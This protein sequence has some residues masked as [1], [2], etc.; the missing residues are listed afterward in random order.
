MAATD[1]DVADLQKMERVLA[2]M[3]QRLGPGHVDCS[4]A[5]ANLARLLARASDAAAL[6][7]FQAAI[8]GYSM[9]LGPEHEKTAA[10]IKDCQYFLAR[11]SSGPG[12]GSGS[13][14]GSGAGGGGGSVEEISDDEGDGVEDMPPV[15]P[16]GGDGDVLP[17]FDDPSIPR[18]RYTI[19]D[20][21]K[22]A[23]W[24]STFFLFLMSKLFKF[25]ATCQLLVIFQF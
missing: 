20:N 1:S 23:S 4:A 14:S 9:T 3:L 15:Q 10:V 2:Q 17:T 12:S 13:G 16:E 5:H 6:P 19:P 18:V 22:Q 21:S 7:H 25:Q 24:L 8:E 11:Q